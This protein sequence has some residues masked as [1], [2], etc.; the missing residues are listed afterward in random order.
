MKV[1]DLVGYKDTW[2]DD[3]GLSIAGLVVRIDRE[4]DWHIALLLAGGKI[5]Q[6]FLD[7]LEVIYN[8]N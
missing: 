5:R 1:G 2:T 7:E 6:G 8:G 3:K 4:L